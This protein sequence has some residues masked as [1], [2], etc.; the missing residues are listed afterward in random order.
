M[1]KIIATVFLTIATVIGA[2]ILIGG[3][4]PS[5]SHSANGMKLAQL[6]TVQRINSDVQILLAVEN[7]QENDSLFI[8]LKNV[9][10]VDLESVQNM[11]LFLTTPGGVRKLSYSSITV[12]ET[13]NYCVEKEN[14]CVFDEIWR[15]EATIKAT[16]NVS[17]LGPGSYS[18]L[19]VL[20][21]GTQARKTFSI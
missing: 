19:V 15:P 1:D 20:P 6:A 21:I 9:G 2:L 7:P 18:V 12:P 17:D 8:W 14:T 16:I 11:D 10:V 5:I 13:W 3:V 4:L